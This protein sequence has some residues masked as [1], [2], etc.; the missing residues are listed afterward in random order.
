MALEPSGGARIEMGAIFLTVR[1]RAARSRRSASEPTDISGTSLGFKHGSQPPSFRGSLRRRSALNS[2]TGKNSGS[3]TPWEAMD[4]YLC[5]IGRTGAM[6]P[7][8]AWHCRYAT[9]SS[10]MRGESHVGTE[11]DSCDTPIAL[12]GAAQLVSCLA[13]NAIAGRSRLLEHSHRRTN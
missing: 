4:D 7:K 1:M 11:G 9:T 10:P 12:T 13:E 6:T 3:T 5:S 8:S 2:C